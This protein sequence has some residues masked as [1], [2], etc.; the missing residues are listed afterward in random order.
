MTIPV[1]T[2]VYGTITDSGGSPVNNAT[3]SI[4]D[5]TSPQGTATGTTNASGEY[6]IN[7][8]DYASDG[9]TI[10]VRCGANH[11]FNDTTFTLDVGDAPKLVNLSLV[12]VTKNSSL[13]AHLE[14]V[15]LK[16]FNLN[17]YLKSIQSSSFSL[18]GHLRAI[19]SKSISVDGHLKDR[20]LQEIR[21]NAFL[22]A[23]QSKTLSLNGTLLKTGNAST[24]AL[25]S[26]LKQII[27]K[28]Y[29]LNAFV[30]GTQSTNYTLNAYLRTSALSTSFGLNAEL[31]LIGRKYDTETMPDPTLK[32]TTPPVAYLN[33]IM[34]DV[35]IKG[36]I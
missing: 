8:M 15:N 2:I 6:Q 24:T 1:P 18:D 4:T 13:N 12:D 5:T 34:P 30:F 19:V 33:E 27:S 16:S 23:I 17:A 7:I 20:T 35:T 11:E 9:D 22:K 21:L 29:S 3:V 32:A 28:S 25:N 26:F 31:I 14:S 36:I 10:R